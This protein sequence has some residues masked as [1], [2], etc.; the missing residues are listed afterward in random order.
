MKSK[1]AR[2]SVITSVFSAGLL[3]SAAITCVHAQEAHA[4]PFNTVPVR[5]S[6]ETSIATGWLP[7]IIVGKNVDVTPKTG[8][9]SETSVAVDPGPDQPEAH[10]HERERPEQRGCCWGL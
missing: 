8:A 5:S 7:P 4:G 10:S 9:Q 3:L 2:L 6:Q 1:C